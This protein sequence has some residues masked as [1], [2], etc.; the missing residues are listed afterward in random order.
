M[1]LR[2]LSL[3]DCVPGYCSFQPFKYTQRAVGL[4]E[5]QGNSNSVTDLVGE[6]V[7]LLKIIR[8]PIF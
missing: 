5:G 7:T 6:L 2:L 1:A 3:L 4:W 8:F